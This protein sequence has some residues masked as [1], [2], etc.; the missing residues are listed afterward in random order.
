MRDK[1]RLKKPYFF[2]KDKYCQKS[3][4]TFITNFNF[5]VIISKQK[6]VRMIRERYISCLLNMSN[7]EIKLG[8]SEIKSKYKDQIKFTDTLKCISYRK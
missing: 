5:K 3:N 2:L 7:K 8:I 4:K 1:L 6:Y